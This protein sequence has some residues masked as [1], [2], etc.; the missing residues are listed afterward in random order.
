MRYIEEQ[1]DRL[2]S[3]AGAMNQP[4]AEPT[5]WVPPMSAWEDEDTLALAVALPGVPRDAIDVAVSDRVLTISG[6][7]HSPWGE[8]RPALGVHVDELHAGAFRRSVVLP[9]R[10]RTEEMTAR[11][12]EGVLELRIPCT[13]EPKDEKRSIPID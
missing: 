10:A 13:R 4:S 8:A 6:S 1:L 5:A 11:M 9:P 7:R 2:V 12:H 3:A